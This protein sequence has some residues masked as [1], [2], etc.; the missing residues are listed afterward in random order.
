MTIILDV[1]ERDNT[2]NTK[3]LRT[4][5]S[6]PAVVYGQGQEAISVAIDAKTFEKVRKEAGESTIIE[7][8]GLDKKVEVLIKEIEFNPVKQIVTHV[9]F[10]SIER[11]KEMTINVH[12][13]F[14][15]EAP[16]EETKIGLV[17]KVLHEVEVTCKPADLPGHIDVNLEVLVGLEDKILIKDLVVG[18]GV[19]IEADEE[20]PV[21]VVSN[22]REE[23]PEEEVETEP[24]DIGDIEVEKKGKEE[25]GETAE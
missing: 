21:V 8:K 9:D 19:K 22:L 4:N 16:V 5:G 12:L 17:N 1:T 3:T 24:L 10:Y 18:K 23:E 25:S 6:V 20:D 11:G 7:L 2:T 13:N 15:G 14:I